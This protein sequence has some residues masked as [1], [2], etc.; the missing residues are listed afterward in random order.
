MMMRKHVDEYYTALL[1]GSL[2]EPLRGQVEEHLRD[3]AACATALQDLRALLAEMRCLPSEIPLPSGFTERVRARLPVRVPHRLPRWLAPALSAG[4]LAAVSLLLLL[5][6]ALRPMSRDL[7]S[8]NRDLPVRISS[9]AVPSHTSTP[10]GS[11]QRHDVIKLVPTKIDL[12][13]G[14]SRHQATGARTISPHAPAGYRNR[15]ADSATRVELALAPPS[16]SYANGDA[17]HYDSGMIPINRMQDGG[18]ATHGANDARVTADAPGN[19]ATAF[20]APKAYDSAVSPSA[21]GGASG[22]SSPACPTCAPK[23]VRAG[24]GSNAGPAIAGS[25]AL[26]TARSQVGQPVATDSD[27]KNP[28]QVCGIPAPKGCNALAQTRTV[29]SCVVADGTLSRTESVNKSLA[30]R[31]STFV[32]A[33]HDV[34]LHCQP[35]SNGNLDVSVLARTAAAPTLQS[36]NQQGVILRVSGRARAAMTFRYM[37][38]PSAE[39]TQ[40]TLPN[41]VSEVSL[42][43]PA[44]SQGSAVRFTIARARQYDSFYLFTPG[45]GARQTSIV[46]RVSSDL[47][48]QVIMPLAS[49]VGAFVLCPADLAERHITFIANGL[50]PGVAWQTLATQEHLQLDQQGRLINITAAGK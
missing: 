25:C 10:N 24:M 3:C 8:K 19:M 18:I 33:Q 17:V 39:A 28:A 1:D 36:S 50:T 21:P 42:S 31:D 32:D 48:R 23:L 45:N 16:A 40:I 47:M 30:G 41:K 43:L 5:G 12:P 13:H 29:L 38:P 15:T 20:M 14:N 22:P 26:P 37:E 9:S 27:D 4:A 49:A 11:A 44:Q 35:I 2:P 6:Y 46:L 7:T 34:L